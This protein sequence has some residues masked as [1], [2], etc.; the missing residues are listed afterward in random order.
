MQRTYKS[1]FVVLLSKS[2]QGT[3]KPSWCAFFA[4]ASFT[5]ASVMAAAPGAARA[6]H[7]QGDLQ[8][9]TAGRPGRRPNDDKHT[10]RQKTK[11]R[12]AR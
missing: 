3:G 4:V 12:R 5:S 9:V 8:L 2:S 6:V 11:T 10:K 7:F 1:A